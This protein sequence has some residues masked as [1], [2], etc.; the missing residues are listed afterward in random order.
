MSEDQQPGMVPDGA[1][2]GDI[3][4]TLDADTL[5]LTV[6]GSF[7]GLTSALMPVGGMDSAGNAESAIH[8]HE[9]PAGSNG[10]IF[11]NLSVVDNGDGSGKFSGRFQ[12]ASAEEA[13]ELLADQYYVNLHTVNNPSGE[14]RGQIDLDSGL[15]DDVT[16]GIPMSEAQEVG[17]TP[18]DNRLDRA[19][20]D[21]LRQ[22][23]ARVYSERQLRESDL[24]PHARRRHG[25]RREPREP[26]PPPFRCGGSKRSDRHQSGRG[27][28]GRR[29]RHLYRQP[30]RSRGSCQRLRQTTFITSTCI[31]T[32]IRA[33]S[34][35]VS[36]R[37]PSAIDDRTV[38][39]SEVVGTANNDAVATTASDE[40]IRALADDDM[41][42]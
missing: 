40:V 22:R 6:S 10:P 37:C 28:Y 14:I 42:R 24:R 34:C 19:L 21:H 9:A 17:T 5:M 18:P 41:V 38:E 11:R 32:T 12:L 39:R 31:P 13:R 1:A 23:H 8:I 15:F 2:T 7:S 33:A 4:A 25:C 3:T 20:R 29:V 36:L 27:R 26:D 30:D 16:S 35:A